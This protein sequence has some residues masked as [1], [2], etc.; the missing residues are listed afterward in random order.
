MIA[1]TR[2]CLRASSS[3]L[4]CKTQRRIPVTRKT[5]TIA[6]TPALNKRQGLLG[7][8]CLLGTL[9]EQSRSVAMAATDLSEADK[10]LL[11]PKWPDKFPFPADA[12]S[13]YDEQVD[14]LFYSSPR[15]VYHIDEKAVNALTKYYTQAFPPSRYYTQAFPPSR[16][17]TQ[18]FPPSGSSD[19]AILDICSSW[20]SHYPEGYKAGRVAGLGMNGD[21]LARNPQLTEFAVQDLNVE[22]KFP[23]EDNSFDVITNCV[24][25]DYL[26]KPLEVFKEIQRCLKPG[27]TAIMSFSN[28]C[29][30]TK[31][32]SI[33][34]Q[35]GDL[36]HIWIVGSYFHY[37]VKGG[38][39]EPVG[40]D[41]S[42]GRGSDPMYVVYATKK[43]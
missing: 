41:I 42:P 1:L 24:S 14:T 21:E 37:S 23:Y 43:A 27:G 20:V 35:T 19:V 26:V 32:I 10:V 40:K 29:F 8:L 31:A 33:W 34:T 3:F 12:F 22:P 2:S 30:P 15:F 11:D 25:V 17:Y 38:F 13:R 16:Y 4:Q 36:D 18:V 39:N 5:T 9:A 7:G 6:S 28:R